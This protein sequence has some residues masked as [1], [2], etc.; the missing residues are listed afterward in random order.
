METIASTV[1][2][3]SA[4]YA[5]NREAQL[6]LALEL[7]ERLATAAQGGPV[8]SRERHVARGKLLPRDTCRSRDRSGPP[9][10]ASAIRSRSS[11]ASSCWVRAIVGPPRLT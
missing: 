2:T 10:A 11:P 9:R 4:T 3:G 5:A 8:K 1:D 6:G 7:Q